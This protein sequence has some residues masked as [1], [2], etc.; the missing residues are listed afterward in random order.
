MVGIEHDTR[1]MMERP[2][3]NVRFVNP[4]YFATL[5]IPIREGR[6]FEEADRSRKVAIISA[7][8]AQRLWSGQNPIGRKLDNGDYLMEVV[9]VTP[10]VRSTSL[11][12]D[13]VNML[14]IPY[15]AVGRT[16]QFAA[17]AYGDGSAR[18]CRRPAPHRSGMWIPKSRSRKR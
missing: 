7:G 11:D 3:T 14:Y 1:P 10:D 18:N 5:R 4:G 13:P 15:F 6:D 17:G 12:H 2:S 8:L 9:G 16:C